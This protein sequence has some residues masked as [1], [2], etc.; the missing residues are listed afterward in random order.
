MSAAEYKSR[1]L[2]T[3][4]RY[5]ETPGLLRKNYLYDGERR[6]G[7]GVYVFDSQEHAQ[8]CFSEEFIKRVSAAYGKPE[9]H[10]FETPILIDNQAKTVS[11]LP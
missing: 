11:E 7:G 8:A 1:M 4:P 3:V 6:L 9:I 5:R 10:F 2:Q